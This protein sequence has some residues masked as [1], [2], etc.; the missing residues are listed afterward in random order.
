MYPLQFH[1]HFIGIGGI[2]MSALA[3]ILKQRGYTVSGSDCNLNQKSIK[4]LQE[5]G[6]IIYD[7]DDTLTC[8]SIIPNVVIYS[9]AVRNNNLELVAAH[10]RNIPMLTRAQLLAHLFNKKEGIAIA[11]AHGKTT[12]SSLIAHIVQQAGYDPTYAIGG[13]LHNYQTN[14]YA[15][16]GNY[17]IAETCEN[18]HTIELVHPTLAVLT[19]VDREHLDV[20]NDLEAIKQAFLSY[21]QNIPFYGKAIICLDDPHA[22][23]LIDRLNHTMQQQVITYGFTSRADIFV[24][25]YQILA[26]RTT[27][28]VRTKHKIIG[29]FT[30]NIPGKH[31]LLNSLAALAVSQEIGIPFATFTD[32][33]K[34]FL[35]IDRRFTL[36][37]SYKGATLYDD[38]GHHP[39][40]IEQIVPVAYK[41]AQEQG[42]RLIILFQPHRYS[43]TGKLWTEFLN[44]LSKAPFNKL[45]ITDIYPAF[46]DPIEQVTSERLVQELHRIDSKEVVYVPEDKNFKQVHQVLDNCIKKNDLVLFLGA[47]KINNLADTLLI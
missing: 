12:T 28:I 46:E 3:I 40:E 44:V 6:C 34:S 45:I 22:A 47:G 17:F 24:E 7:S 42:G 4:Q 31:N 27:A 1:F 35:G 18:D 38:Y 30:L 23:S 26:D 16:S 20:Y 11:G 43:R 39:T 37:G 13:H 29:S 10:K 9:A 32:A 33:C 8:L 15:G 5:L 21:L 36:K 14:A 25:D 2:G 19:N 41:K